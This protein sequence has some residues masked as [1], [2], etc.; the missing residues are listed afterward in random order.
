MGKPLG[1]TMLPVM[2]GTLVAMLQGFP[3]LSVLYIGFPI[4]LLLA[5]FWTWVRLR[6]DICEILIFEHKI[7]LRSIFSAAHPIEDLQWKLLIDL[8]GG[9]DSALLT[10]GLEQF[11]L[12]MSDWPEWSRLTEHLQSTL[13]HT[14]GQ[15]NHD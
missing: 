12:N 6:S 10:V 11:T 13:L 9:I 7:A 5:F 15:G 3:V 14:L 2:I 4:A 8:R 1:I